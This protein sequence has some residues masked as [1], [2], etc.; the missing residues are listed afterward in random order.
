MSQAGILSTT[1]GGGT[2]IQ[3]IN[4]D[5]GSITG[6]TVTIYANNAANNA[7]ATVKFVNSGTISTLN[8]TDTH[9]NTTLG[10][11]AGGSSMSAV[12]GRNTA[13]GYQ[14]FQNATSAQQ[15]VAIGYQ[16][17]GSNSSGHENTAVGA[18]CLDNLV[19]SARNTATG[20]QAGN[21]SI[22]GND[23]CFFGQAAGW[24]LPHG[25]QNVMVG[26][27]SGQNMI[28]NASNNIFVGFQSGNNYVLNESSNILIGNVGVVSENNIIRIGTTGS[29][30]GQQ[31]KA[32]LAGVTG[33]TVASSP[34]GIASSGQ[35]TDLGYGIAGQ[36][37]TSNGS[38]NSP[39]WQTTSGVLLASG[40]LTNNQI[41]N[42]H[43]TPFQVV[44]APGAG[45]V[46][47]V[48]HAIMTLNYGGNNAFVNGGGSSI[49]L[50]F[51]TSQ[52]I[53]ASLTN[54]QITSTSSQINLSAAPTVLSVA[55]S[56]ITNLALNLW[57]PSATE[58]SGNAANDNTMSYSVLYRIV[59][60]P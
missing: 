54:A 11:S 39:T 17:L 4:G 15:C 20:Q 36:V 49:T 12:V 9:A 8:F 37:F 16:A 10:Q 13:I 48:L 26:S 59:T 47:Q 41:K 53:V 23:N 19:A 34:A 46:I 33:V 5:T 57:N 52:S 22:D 30:A 56:A 42:L 55:Y 43:G 18:A 35:L 7:G 28:G 6:S 32:F 50:Y 2:P 27:D 51:S 44:A 21:Q 45:A 24:Q 38:P 3:T 1:S 40:N 31:N 29:G 60:I 58:I 14:S 25:N